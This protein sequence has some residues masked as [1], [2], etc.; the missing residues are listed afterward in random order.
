MAE[1]KGGCL[2]GAVRFTAANVETDF[3]T[4]H[5]GMC[6][7]W[8]GSPVFAAAAEGVEF[9][10]EDTLRVYD[11]SEWASRGFCGKCGSNLFYYLKPADKYIMCV[12]TF[13]DA[14]PFRLV[15]E[16]YIDHKP[17]GYNFAGD[18]PKQTEAE[19]LAKFSLPE[20]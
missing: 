6:R 19:F 4:C 13:D 3:E 14:S 12:G 2:C 18:L 11:S 17:P 5:C 20:A 7:R 9:A 10:G 16:I 1:M 15:G 8:A